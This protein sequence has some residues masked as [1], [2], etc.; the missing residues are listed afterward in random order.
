MPPPPTDWLS[1]IKEIGTYSAATIATGIIVASALKKWVWKWHLDDAVKAEKEKNE[2]IIA[3]L[4]DRYEAAI[5]ALQEQLTESKAS[6]NRWM[7][8]SVRL[9]SQNEKTRDLIQDKLT[10]QVG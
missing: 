6:E 4:K 3:L 7:T 8:M 10:G 5:E 2:A 1:F 9:L